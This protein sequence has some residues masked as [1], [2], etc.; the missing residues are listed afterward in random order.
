MKKLLFALAILLSCYASSCKGDKSKDADSADSGQTHVN[1]AQP[2]DSSKY[3]VSP[4]ETG[5]QDT[6]SSAIDPAKPADTIKRR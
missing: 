2:A 5:G 6:S 4:V 1:S 3:P